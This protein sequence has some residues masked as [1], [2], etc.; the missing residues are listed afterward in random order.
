MAKAREKNQET[1]QEPAKKGRSK[2]KLLLFLLAG[3]LLLAALGG[4][5]YW[6]YQQYLAP[7]DETQESA[8]EQEE[9]Q[10]KSDS[11]STELVSLPSMLVNLADPMGKRY[12]KV[13]IELEVE[14]KKAESRIQDNMSR[15]KDALILLLSSKSFS[16]LSSIE[17]KLS[18][19]GEIVE[20]INQILDDSAVHDIYFTEFV[21]Q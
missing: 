3:L 6:G 7:E 14:G 20:R 17:N 8:Q 18:L 2:I 4:L 16:D 11:D 19:K 5:G 15:I 21:V 1:N 9:K 10:E 12:L 13:S